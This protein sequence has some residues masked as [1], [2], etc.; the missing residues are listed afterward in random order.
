MAPQVTTNTTAQHL[1]ASHAQ[2]TSRANPAAVIATSGVSELLWNIADP[3]LWGRYKADMAIKLSM[4][5]LTCRADAKRML[6]GFD[7][8]VS[9]LYRIAGVDWLLAEKDQFSSATTFQ[10][11]DLEEGLP[12]DNTIGPL[13]TRSLTD[14][15]HQVREKAPPN[16]RKNFYWRTGLTNASQNGK[17]FAK[18]PRQTAGKYLRDYPESHWRKVTKGGTRTWNHQKETI[19]L[20]LMTLRK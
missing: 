3:G 19:C 20:R 6:N 8:T 1:R 4:K 9:G 15:R 7:P 16:R 11:V 17:Q 12:G 14:V 2:G 18:P 5:T 13:N 10:L